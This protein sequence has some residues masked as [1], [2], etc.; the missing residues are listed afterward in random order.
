MPSKM[1]KPQALQSLDPRDYK[2]VVCVAGTRF[3]NDRRYFHE[4]ILEFL[5]DQTEP[6]LFVSGD[7]T[8]GADDLII[9]W[10][11]KFR[12]PC[13]KMPADWDNQQGLPNFN[14]KAQGFI[15]NE[16]MSMVITYLIAFW[17]H[18]STGTG[19]MIECCENRHIPMQKIKIPTPTRP[20]YA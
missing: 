16:K 8:S 14:K 20:N 7:A 5:E 10:C 13:L 19:H 4:K 12:Y 17:D 9:R 18:V 2:V 11:D 6:V 3:W 1:P 15:R